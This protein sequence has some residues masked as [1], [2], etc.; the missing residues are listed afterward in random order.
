[1]VCGFEVLIPCLLD[2]LTATEI[3]GLSYLAG[4]N[5]CLG[6]ADDLVEELIYGGRTH[7]RV[8]L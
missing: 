7:S 1:M 6:M 8:D 5:W 2:V 3:Q 4:S